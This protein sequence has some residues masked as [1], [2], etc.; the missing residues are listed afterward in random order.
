MVWG[1]AQGDLCAENLSNKK[2]EVEVEEEALDTEAKVKVLNSLDR[3]QKQRQEPQ[4]LVVDISRK[5]P[6]PRPLPFTSHLDFVQ[7]KVSCLSPH[8]SC[9]N[10]F[11][12]ASTSTKFLAS[13]TGAPN[14]TAMNRQHQS[15]V[16]HAN[17]MR[18]NRHGSG[19]S[20]SANA[21][22]VSVVHPSSQKTIATP[23]NRFEAIKSP[24]Q[25]SV[26]YSQK[27]RSNH[28]KQI[29]HPSTPDK[30][31][32]DKNKNYHQA[33]S[34]HPQDD[35]TEI[36]SSCNNKSSP[37]SSSNLATAVRLPNDE[38]DENDE[39]YA[40]FAKTEMM[41]DY[42]K[43][44]TVLYE[45]LEAS[46]WEEAK[47]RAKSHTEEVWT[48][49]IRKD[50]NQRVRWKLMPL[51]ASIIFQAPTSVVV[52]LL[53]LYPVAARRR[54]DQGMLPLHLA[55][56][57]KQDDEALLEALLK[58]FPK[59][60][61]LKDKRQ[62]VPLDHG[63]DQKFSSKIMRLYSDAHVVAL[64]GDKH[65]SPISPRR[66]DQQTTFVEAELAS[67]KQK[68]KEDLGLLQKHYEEK[69]ATV[70]DQAEQDARKGKLMVENERQSL[71]ESHNQQVRDL[72]AL[73]GNQAG[74]ENT[75]MQDLQAQIDYLQTALESANTKNDK[76][77]NRYKAVETYN[78]E[79]RIQLHRIVQD[80]LFI[81]DLATRQNNEVEAARRSRA[82]I[83][84]TLIQQE[85][86]D[87][88]NDQMRVSKLV[89]LTE[90]VRDRVQNL[91]QR[92]PIEPD[93]DAV[94]AQPYHTKGPS[95]IDA[96]GQ[97]GGVTKED[98]HSLLRQG[99][100][101]HMQLLEQREEVQILEDHVHMRDNHVDVTNLLSVSMADDISTITEHSP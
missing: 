2:V 86:T 46:S 56:R 97:R 15:V 18:Q 59:A 25:P 24:S 8:I 92:S 81:R 44:A 10:P 27:M 7:D 54:D 71:I 73:V 47:D 77:E 61:F 75:M 53:G 40:N 66:P 30:N 29:V 49:I 38:Q 31:G 70:R 34:L 52:S 91:M 51:H 99:E 12:A 82:Q 6:G 5:N 64:N 96:E 11:A 89:E 45:L 84:Q 41:C 3:Q 98:G 20:V 37:S 95:R 23:K 72:R 68:H 21:P 67:L 88:H 4:Y 35:E 93:D 78:T 74:R 57:H 60:V 69:L 42:D 48:W 55:F 62:R 16:A 9:E 33:T 39:D 1:F 87:Q 32:L 100:H 17:R 58:H 76:W 50:K 90:N 36:T 101:F 22:T 80:Q 63:R 19:G 43:S 28:P 65:F 85:D 94:V 13:S 83:V 79:L 26:V 14:R